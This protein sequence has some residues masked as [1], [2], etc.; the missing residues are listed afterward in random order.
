MKYLFRF[1]L[2]L[3]S[4]VVHAQ[5]PQSLEPAAIIN[6]G[7]ETIQITTRDGEW[8]T[9]DYAAAPEGSM[10]ETCINQNKVP[11]RVVI[12]L[13]G[14]TLYDSGEYLEDISGATIKIN[15]N[16]STLHDNKPYKI[17]LQKK[18][19]LLHR[20]NQRYADKNW[21]LL[22]D[23]RTLKT[24]IGLKVNHLLGL[25]WTPA[26][27]PCNVI[28]NDD[29]QGCYLLIES[30][31][32]N[33]NCRLDVSKSTGYIVE[34]DPYW[35]K[36]TTYFSSHYFAQNKAYRWTWKYPD[37]EDVTAEQQRYIENYLNKTENSISE[38][39]YQ[40]YIDTES[41]ARWILAHDILA[42]WDSGGSNLYIM[43]YD[44]SDTT[45]VQMANLWDFDTIFKMGEGNFSR[46]H[47]SSYDFYF[48]HLFNSN[49]TLFTDTYKRLWQTVKPSLLDSL[50]TFIENYVASTEAEALQQSRLCYTQRWNYELD[51]VEDDAEYAINWFCKH[52]PLLDEKINN[53]H[54]SIKALPSAGQNTDVIYNI[55]GQPIDKPTPG[56]YIRNGHKFIVK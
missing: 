44:H 36:E 46:Y 35:W 3:C 33:S 31:E 45:R 55:K 37:D 39:T 28:I 8:P 30:V 22:K 49:N 15:G 34:R 38:G 12:T 6:L 56:I 17:K 16:T 25:P 14:D 2:I 42:T 50:T 27:R 40:D 29:Y 32:R 13:Y 23:A 18:A 26:Y 1:L 47:D 11:C 10:G 53:I 52:L 19:D 21:R 5:A 43:K 54:T 9:C 41:F 20:N 7:L 24:M 48:H 4:V 51:T